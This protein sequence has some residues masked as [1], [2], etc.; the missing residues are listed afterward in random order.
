M[1]TDDK[2]N[3]EF[4]L[5]ENEDKDQSKSVPPPS[6]ISTYRKH[7]MDYFARDGVILRTGFSNLRDWFLLCIRELLDN[8][9]DFLVRYYQGADNCVIIVEVFKDDNFF[10]LKVK[11]SNFNNYKVFKN[12]AAIFNYDGRYG[13]KQDLHIISRGM[14]GD[15]QKQI[16]AFGYILIHL[17]D[18][19][20]EFEEK[21]WEKP[22]IIRHNGKEYKIYLKVD[23]A[24]QTEAVSGLDQATGDVPHTDTE[25]ELTLPIPDEVQNELNRACIESFCK[26]YPLFT[27]DINFKFQITDNSSYKSVEEPA[28]K[29]G[30]ERPRIILTT[31]VD[32]SPKAT[33]NIEYNALH[34]ISR[35]PWYKQN[36]VHSYTAEEFKRRIVNMDSKQAS[37]ISVYDFLTTHREGS[38]IKKT[39]EN[40]MSVAELLSLPDKDRDKRIELFYYQLKAALPPLEKLVMQYTTNK[41]ERKNALIERCNR[42]YRNLDKDRSKAAYRA[43]YGKYEDRKKKISYPYF[44]EILAIPFDDPRSANNNVVFIG[45]VNYSISPKDDSNLFEGDYSQY[46]AIDAYSKPRNILGVLEI[47]GF[48]EYANDTAKI[49]CLIVANLVTHR[50]DPHGQDK[51]RI[52]IT[53]FAGTIVKA[54][55]K[56]T[57]EIKSYRAVGIRFSKPSERRSAIQYGSGRGLLEGVLTDYLQKNHGL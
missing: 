17:N 51:S 9:V 3:R 6:E 1:D 57:S 45:A 44:F 16:L 14:L 43:I 54:V 12:K 21:Q 38:N 30:S 10:R 40:E 48:H 28:Q 41:K 53:P 7:S 50:R 52:D 42:L 33:L 22:L 18:N 8:A 36:T 55:K 11:N 15:A 37:E 49:P 27:T 47:L 26:K 13:S 46:V 56:L 39:F 5:D 29:S 34:P 32:E 31:L 20:S 4:H 19:G 2:N 35:E 23:K 25:I 24:R